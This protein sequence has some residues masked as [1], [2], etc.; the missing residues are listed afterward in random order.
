LSKREDLERIARF[1]GDK[2]IARNIERVI[3]KTCRAESPNEFAIWNKT[4][5]AKKNRKM[6]PNKKIIFSATWTRE[7]LDKLIGTC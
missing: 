6:R 1:C 3:A 7:V 4:Y 5:R 2:K